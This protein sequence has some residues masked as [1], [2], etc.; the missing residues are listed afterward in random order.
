VVANSVASVDD[1]DEAFSGLQDALNDLVLRAAK[2]GLKSAID[3]AGVIVANASAY[4]PA[5][6]VGL[7][8][9]HTAAQTVYADADATSAQV[10]ATQSALV[11]KI[12][13]ARL[14]AASPSAPLS[15]G[16]LSA[17]AA[18]RLALA[19]VGVA[20]EVSTEQAE[21]AALPGG[22]GDTA[23]RAGAL[24]GTEAA[25]SVKTAKPKVVGQT[26][27][28]KKLRAK[29]GAWS[30]KAAVAYQWFA[31]GKPIAKATKASYKVTRADVGKRLTVRVTAT[32]AG[33]ETGV[34]TSAKTARV[35]K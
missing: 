18:E 17:P 3:V 8:E 21:I 34:A 29:V 2:A 28:G 23:R 7:A 25:K 13:L 6:L 30:K 32:K 35:K 14:R 15:A 24:T 31:D 22:G 26:R 1:V 16:L 12:A 11:A 9:A 5:S 4:V 20:E 33:F 19:P 27:V 10:G